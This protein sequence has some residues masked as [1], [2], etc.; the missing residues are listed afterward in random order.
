M[1]FVKRACIRICFFLTCF[2]AFSCITIAATTNTK[3]YYIGKKPLKGDT[4]RNINVLYEH[5][6]DMYMIQENGTVKTFTNHKL[7]LFDEYEI[8]AAV[9]HTNLV[10]DSSLLNKIFSIGYSFNGSSR[11]TLNR[12]VLLATGVF[13]GNIQDKQLLNRRQDGYKEFIFR[14]T[15]AEI[16]IEFV[17]YYLKKRFDYDLRIGQLKWANARQKEKNENAME[18]FALG[19]FYLSFAIVFCLLFLFFRS[20]KDHLYFAL[21]CLFV[22]MALTL[23]RLSDISFL[24]N[25]S[26]FSLVIS[27]EFLSIFFA[28]VL[29]NREK[30]KLPV[31]IM[32]LA[33]ILLSIPAVH[34]S[35][36]FGYGFSLSV[37]CFIVGVV[38][39]A[40]SALYF[41]IQGIGQ[42]KWEAKTITAGSLI[43]LALTIIAPLVLGILASQTNFKLKE[44]YAW[45]NYLP[46]IGLCIYPITVA[47]VLGKRNAINQEQLVQQVKSIEK[48]SNENMEREKEKK[49][50]L[51]EQNLLLETKVEE[52]TRELAFKNELISVKNREITDSLMYAKRI[53][54]S[55][56]PDIKLIYR[57]L[58]QSFILY[59]PK[60]IVSG[61]FYSFAQKDDKVIIAAAD[62]TGH[63]VAGAFMSM[64][65]SAL[66]NQIINEKHITDPAHILDQLNDGVIHSLK[67]RESES[68]DGMDI[69]ICSFDLKNNYMHYAGANRPLWLV[70]NGALIT[71][72]PDKF[73]IGGLQVERNA[74][75]VSHEIILQKNDTIYL[76]SDGY[77]DQFGG[78]NGKKLMSKKF[79]DT[80]LDIQHLSMRDQEKFLHD[81]FKTWKGKNEQVDDVLVIGIKI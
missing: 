73:P 22:A 16:T 48:L 27:I 74:K 21:F 17:P 37:I 58:D 61:D 44:V 28:R 23:D 39:A 14:D 76:F 64:I 38:Y 4:I 71:Y 59:L 29:V 51:E 35:F 6:W 7:G 43:G 66:I 26:N 25:F 33:G 65:G 50:I 54:A 12:N 52:R 80:L 77:A 15:L 13:A 70:R 68:N 30:S 55:I 20:N 56:L 69:S 62:C 32:S 1:V 18:Y 60:D 81:L 24:I 41:L 63:G 3:I 31:L 67:Q 36:N 42:K 5:L 78:E 40:F 2:F 34:Y 79:K 57:T 19:S 45:I 75:F 8:E 11:I 49:K 10:I 9:L 53:Q 72:K 47:I 46:D